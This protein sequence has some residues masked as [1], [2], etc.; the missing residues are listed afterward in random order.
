MTQ[1]NKAIATS[2]VEAIRAGSS[3]NLCGGL[4]KG[5][6][7]V[8]GNFYPILVCPQWAWVASYGMLCNC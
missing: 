2:T 6:L 4:L 5:L 7:Y 1:D 8:Y 3:T